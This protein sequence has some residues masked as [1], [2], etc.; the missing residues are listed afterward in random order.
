MK[1]LEELYNE[2]R[3]DEGLKEKLSPIYYYAGKKSNIEFTI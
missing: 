2:I 1:T 3:A